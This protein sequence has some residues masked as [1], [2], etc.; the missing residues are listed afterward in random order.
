LVG[1]K[2]VVP[3]AWMGVE[4]AVETVALR[5]E[6]L[7]YRLAEMWVERWVAWKA[8]RMVDKWVGEKV[9]LKVV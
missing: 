1:V 4:L 7:V 2:A 3:A 6:R 5:A 9:V 8:A